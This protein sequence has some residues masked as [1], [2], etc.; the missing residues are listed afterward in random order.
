MNPLRLQPNK[1][2]RSSVSG[3][4]FTGRGDRR[5][6]ALTF[7]KVIF[8]E[9]FLMF[10]Y[11]ALNFGKRRFGART[12]IVVGSHTGCVQC[13]GGKSQ[14]QRKTKFMLMR[15]LFQRFMEQDRIGGIAFQEP[16][17][18]RN[19]MGGFTFNGFAQFWFYMAVSDFHWSA[20]CNIGGA[21]EGRVA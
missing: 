15:I 13:A 20:L 1:E 2:F 8:A 11:L 12:N 6:R 3:G 16:V 17:E 14:I 4:D 7:P 9:F 5:A 19:I 21:A 18:L 10:L